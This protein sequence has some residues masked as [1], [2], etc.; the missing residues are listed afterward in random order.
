MGFEEEIN[1]EKISQLTK[2]ERKTSKLVN[3]DAKFYSMLI[4]HLKKLQE[5]YNKKYLEAPTSTEALLL[6]NEICKLDS[7]I[8]EIYARRER[9]II[10]SALDTNSTP[11]FKNMLEH[12]QRL[13]DSLTKILN[14]YKEEVLNQK[15]NPSCAEPPEN[16][17][18]ESPSLPLGTESTKKEIEPEAPRQSVPEQK[19]PETKT[20]VPEENELETDIFSAEQISAKSEKENADQILVYVM[21]DME[22]FVGTDLVTYDLHK[23]DIVT[24]PR[25]TADILCKNNKVRIV[26]SDV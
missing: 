2:K 26:E 8:K 15:L 20:E 25:S 23:E 7:M 16:L 17:T 19:V 24:I 13:Y 3:L 1:Y 4:A 12:E 18:I 9:K 10:L 5:G 21:E 22:P 11:G 14:D 6:N